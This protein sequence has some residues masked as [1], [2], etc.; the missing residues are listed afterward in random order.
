MRVKCLA[1]EHNTCPCP[2]LETGPL[3]PESSALE[4]KYLGETLSIF[5]DTSNDEVGGESKGTFCDAY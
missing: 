2:G 5:Q 4:E 1:Q 3:A